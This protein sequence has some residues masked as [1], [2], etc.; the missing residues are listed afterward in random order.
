MLAV[1]A[2]MWWWGFD[3]GQIFGGLNRKEIDAK[4]A[5]FDAEVARLRDEA[6]ELRVRNSRLESDLAMSRGAEQA[7]SRQANDMVAENAQLK[8][9]VVFLQKLVADS[10]KQAGLSIPRL[11][12][13]VDPDG[14]YRY[15]M[16]VVRG[17]NPKADFEGH[18]ALQA[19]VA[20]PD[21]GVLTL[22]LPEDQPETR[23]SLELRFKYYQRV[24][25]TLKL[26]AGSRLTELTARAY[27][28]GSASPRATRTLT[29]P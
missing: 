6:V 10:S 15:R 22:T 9:E 26:P 21:G 24:E 5:T 13:D 27:E 4:L 25:G 23:S 7:L 8:E 17:G 14:T 29:S 19:A 2:G 20:A 12:V 3:F 11:T 28:D 18:M 1:V 16:I